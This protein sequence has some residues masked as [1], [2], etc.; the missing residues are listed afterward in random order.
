MTDGPSQTLDDPRVRRVMD[1][2]RAHLDAELTLDELAK[3]AHVSSYHFHR[4][5]KVAAGETLAQF[6]RRAR[7]ERAAYLMKAAPSRALT[8]IALEVGFA[9]PSELSRAFRKAFG[10]APRD[11][12]RRSRLGEPSLYDKDA[13]PQPDEPDEP[14]EV[15]VRGHP[16]M[17]LA[18]VRVRWLAEPDALPRG[19]EA[20]TQRLTER[21]VDW[22]ACPLVGMSWD[23]YET[24]PI[25]RVQFDLGFS[26]GPDVPEDDVLG[27]RSLPAITAAQTRA[28][29]P[30]IRI[31]RAWD[32]LY[33]RWLPGSSYEPDDLPAMKRFAV[34]PDEGGWE[35]WDVDCSIPVR[36]RLG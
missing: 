18:Y 34:R 1:H 7:L 21:G 22:K 17:R 31:A 10:I 28:T 16:P 8:S 19:Y 36:R 4:V 6:T 24:T 14:F 5:F 3:V 12:D 20:L 29:G 32:H 23:N 27:V 9:S 11:W 30:M 33:E 25:E 2:V 35:Q 15:V 26:V 13:P